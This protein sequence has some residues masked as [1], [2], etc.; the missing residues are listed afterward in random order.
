MSARAVEAFLARIYVDADARLRF[1]R[2]PRAEAQSAGLSEEECAALENI[3]WVGL[4]MA[5]RSFAHK[6]QARLKQNRASA[7][8]DRWHRFFAALSKRLRSVF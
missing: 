2:N 8:R 5:A 3:D 6:R 4:E 1:K 7:F